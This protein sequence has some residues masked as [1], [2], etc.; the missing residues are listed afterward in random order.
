MYTLRVELLNKLDT[1]SEFAVINILQAYVH[2]PNYFPH[3]LYD[4]VKEM[5]AVTLDHNPENLKSSFLLD[6]LE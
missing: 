6:V 5:I 3:D 4:E 1:I 2:L